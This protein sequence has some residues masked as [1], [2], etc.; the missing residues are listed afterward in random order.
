MILFSRAVTSDC[1][2]SPAIM[3]INPAGEKK[4]IIL[5]SWA[6]DNVQFINNVND[7]EYLSFRSYNLVWFFFLKQMNPSLR[8]TCL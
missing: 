8:Y 4:K 7:D 5:I 1:P 2:F 3:K 6:N